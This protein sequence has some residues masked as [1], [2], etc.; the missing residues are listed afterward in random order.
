MQQSFYTSLSAMNA[1]LKWLDRVSNNIANEN[2]VGYAASTGTF[3]D[4]FTQALNGNATDGTAAPRYT[5]PGWWGG[6]GVFATSEHSD[7]SQMPIQ[8]TGNPLDFAIEGDGFFVVRGANGQPLLTKAGN[9]QW[10]QVQGGRFMLATQNG[11]A[12]LDTTGQPIVVSANDTNRIAVAPNGQITVNGNPGQR[13][14]IAE[15]ALP[16]EHLS[17]AGNNEFAIQQGARPVIVNAGANST[18]S[19]IQG[20]LSMSNVDMT[21][22]MTDMIQAQR[23]FD[24]N[25]EALQLT[26]K[27]AEVA[28]GIRS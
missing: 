26:D 5:P 14:A 10:S 13:I 1:S 21:V 24:L 19:V 23:M 15:L 6:T 2:T 25:A 4:T 20:A 9:F 11:E 8:Q 27:M 3:A 12:V 18:S 7:F 17:A 28:N 16:E 22:E